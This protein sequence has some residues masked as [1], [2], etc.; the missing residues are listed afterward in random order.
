MY[1][2][3]G[4][5]KTKRAS[6][7]LQNITH[8]HQ[9]TWSIHISYMSKMCILNIANIFAGFWIRACWVLRQIREN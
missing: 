2:Q 7:I 1:K 6:H 8:L 3:L 4:S 9:Y 5:T